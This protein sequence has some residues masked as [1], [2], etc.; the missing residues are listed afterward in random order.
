[1]DPLPMSLVDGAKPHVSIVT[2]ATIYKKC[3][4]ANR[5]YDTALWVDSVL[6]T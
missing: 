5:V 4:L 6:E 1:M 3:N 2:F